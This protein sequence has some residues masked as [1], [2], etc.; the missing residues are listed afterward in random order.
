MYMCT[1][2]HGQGTH[3][4][5]R[6][7]AQEAKN[8][9][10]FKITAIHYKWA[11]FLPMIV[12]FYFKNIREKYNWKR[13]RSVGRHI[14]S[15]LWFE[16]PMVIG[17]WHWTFAFLKQKKTMH[18]HCLV[19]LC[20][21]MGRRRKNGSAKNIRG[22][23]RE[24]NTCKL[25]SRYELCTMKEDSLSLCLECVHNL[26]RRAKNSLFSVSSFALSLSLGTRYRP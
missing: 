19:C 5:M 6:M 17:W 15:S 9:K 25:M 13:V 18:D 7:Y 21:Y 1:Q 4:V 16:Q 22:R 20:A 12:R 14:Y 8:I 3:Y 11:P 10:L 23:K 24:I 26:K 2:S